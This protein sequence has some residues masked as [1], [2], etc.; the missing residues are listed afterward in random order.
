L[1]A[2]VAYLTVFH[3]IVDSLRVTPSGSG[4]AAGT[5]AANAQTAEST[6]TANRTGVDEGARMA[7]YVA[8]E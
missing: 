6:A 8:F 3:V 2:S 7:I 4:D 5:T 1:S